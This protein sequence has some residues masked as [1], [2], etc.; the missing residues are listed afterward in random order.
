[1]TVKTAPISVDLANRLIQFLH[2]LT[3]RGDYTG[4]EA[5][6]L[7]RTLGEALAIVSEHRERVELLGAELVEAVGRATGRTLRTELTPATLAECTEALADTR[8]VLGA[9]VINLPLAPERD[10]QRALEAAAARMF[11]DMPPPISVRVAVF[12]HGTYTEAVPFDAWQVPR[13][14]E[15]LYATWDGHTEQV[16]VDRVQW[17]NGH[18]ALLYTTRES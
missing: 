11:A 12:E 10:T 13:A 17:D 8:P 6:Y 7:S 18:A 1:M 5:R 3:G 14:G 2:P 15:T 4:D 9:E 16:R